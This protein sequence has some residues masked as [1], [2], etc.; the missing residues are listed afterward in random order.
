MSSYD[1]TQITRMEARKH[2]DRARQAVLFERITGL[3]PSRSSDLLPFEEVRDRLRLVQ[4]T[5]RGVQEIPLDLIIGSVGRYR[6]FTRTFL[7]R[8]PD[9]QERWQRVNEVAATQGV[10]PIEVYQIGE[11]YFVLDGNHRVSVAKQN[12]AKTIEAHVWEF[13]TPAGLSAQA[14]LDE[15]LVKA[16]YAQFLEWS[17]LD[18]LRPEAQIIFTTP[19]RYQELEV[20]IELYRN[21]LEKID[22]EPV[23]LEDAVTAWYDM[24]YTPAVQIIQEQGILD[25]FPN[26]TEAD[27]FI[28]TWRYNQELSEKDG[29]VHLAQTAGELAQKARIGPIGR[30]WERIT[31]WLKDHKT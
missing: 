19:G 10:P 12:G 24:I 28:W 27:L 22:E 15:V 17:K 5:Y 1:E 11:V 7:P 31:G 25:L 8:N 26:R 18:Q 3:L 2:W 29:P 13:P 20:Q 21:A 4:K 14:D 23:S 9:L 30:I 16:E 6:D